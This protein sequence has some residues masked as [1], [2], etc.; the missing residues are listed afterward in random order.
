M[1][2][3]GYKQK[4]RCAAGGSHVADKIRD[5]TLTHSVPGTAFMQPDW[6][7]CNKCHVMFFDG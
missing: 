5:F 6:R 2:F 3:N 7:F 1:F 4:G